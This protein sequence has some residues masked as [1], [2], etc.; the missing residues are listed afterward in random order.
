MCWLLKCAPQKKA[1]KQF[2]DGVMVTFEDGTAVLYDQVGLRF[3]AFLPSKQ[4][5][6]SRYNTRYRYAHGH[7]TAR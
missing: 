4:D 6:H 1:S 2:A 3:G 5:T 7:R